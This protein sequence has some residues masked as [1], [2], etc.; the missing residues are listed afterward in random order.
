MKK[1]RKHSIRN[2][3][4]LVFVT[5][6][7]ILL[8]I[9][10]FMY[11]NVNHMINRLDEVYVSNISLNELADTLLR[12][13]TSMTD[14]LNTRTSDAMEDYYR[15]EQDYSQLVS[16]LNDQIYGND[17]M[18]MERNIRHM[19]EEYLELTGQ[20][21]DAKRGGNVEK[22][23]ARY[24]KATEIYGYI[25]TYIYSLNNE[26]FRINSGS[27]QALSISMHYLEWIN[28]AALLLVGVC[29]LLLISLLTGT[30]T[31][32]LQRLAGTA[33]QVARG[34]LDV[35][36]RYQSKDELGVLSDQFREVVR[37]L[38]AIVD[39]ENQFLAKMASGDLTVDSICEQVYAQQSLESV[40]YT[41]ESKYT[42]LVLLE[43]IQASLDK[44]AA[45][46]DATG[47]D[48]E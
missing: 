42:S 32:P 18:L 1:I 22:V 21:I 39:D 25:S 33:D 2:K 24:E 45:Q 17:L 38:R 46:T 7:M 14:Y 15:N 40:T 34:N 44:A 10:L 43:A 11:A 35:E 47:A 8:L 31:S 26:Q 48:G 19:S 6:T 13:Q 36:I 4:M 23:K 12:V 37:K 5:T 27:Y 30:I 28:V 16:G 9:N 20:T 3:M 41:A 29:N